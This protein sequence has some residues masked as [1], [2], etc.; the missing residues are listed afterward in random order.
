MQNFELSFY[1]F[2]M[3]VAEKKVRL[4][5]SLSINLNIHFILILKIQIPEVH[6]VCENFREWYI[7]GTQSPFYLNLRKKFQRI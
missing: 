4:I 6:L 5:Q 2:I 1:T 3:D 7:L